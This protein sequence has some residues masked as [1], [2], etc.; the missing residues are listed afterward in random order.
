[1]N[2]IRESGTSAAS[3]PTKRGRRIWLWIV[4][5]GAGLAVVWGAGGCAL[6]GIVS[7]MGDRGA[8]WETGDAVGVIYVEGAMKGHYSFV[9]LVLIF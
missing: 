2:G 3:P 1:M 9:E 8:P 5:I 7:S 6:L 4:G